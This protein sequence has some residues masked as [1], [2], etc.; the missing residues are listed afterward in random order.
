MIGLVFNLKNNLYY[1][2]KGRE[3]N[4]GCKIEIVNFLMIDCLFEF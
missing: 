2:Y 1:I 4:K 3:E